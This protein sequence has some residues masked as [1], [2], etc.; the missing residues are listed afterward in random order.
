MESGLTIKRN[1]ID[2]VTFVIGPAAT[3]FMVHKEVACKYSPVWKAA[4]DG[5]MVEGQT[6]T[7]IMDDVDPEDFRSVVQWIYAG[8]IKLLCHEELSC[9]KARAQ[10]ADQTL[11]NPD[12]NGRDVNET[13]TKRCWDFQLCGEQDKTLVR[14]WVL[15]DKLLMD[16]FQNY[17]MDILIGT[18]EGCTALVEDTYQYIYENTVHGSPLRDL[19]VVERVLDGISYPDKIPRDALVDIIR[20]HEIGL[21]EVGIDTDDI[22]NGTRK[23][24]NRY[25]HVNR[26]RRNNAD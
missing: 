21:P 2:L 3:Q 14:L 25:F 22:Y 7:Y 20:G 13:Q 18:F 16:D 10:V 23:L 12:A 19:V 24:D 8:K 26:G 6:Q 15:A 5:P 11:S 4:F 9:P 1:P 17:V